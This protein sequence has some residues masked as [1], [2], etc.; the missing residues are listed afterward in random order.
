MLRRVVW[1]TL[2][3]V[4]ELLTDPVMRAARGLLTALMMNII[5][6]SYKVKAF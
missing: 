6:I 2:T 5:I 4:S 1:Q 3:D